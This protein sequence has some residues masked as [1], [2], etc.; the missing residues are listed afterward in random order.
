[1]VAPR[2]LYVTVPRGSGGDRKTRV[3]ATQTLTA[4]VAKGQKV[5]ELVV[6][7]PGRA[8]T[9]L[10]LVAGAAVAEAGPVLAAWNWLKSLVGY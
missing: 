7:V 3:V 1:M 4:P 10:P 6:S 2:D 8:D 5:G 9:R